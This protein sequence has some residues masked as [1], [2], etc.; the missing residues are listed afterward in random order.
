MGPL[1]L[2][3]PSPPGVDGWVRTPPSGPKIPLVNALLAPNLFISSSPPAY[4]LFPGLKGHWIG[5]FYRPN[6]RC[7]D[8]EVQYSFGKPMTK[9]VHQLMEFNG[10]RYTEYYSTCQGVLVCPHAGENS[11]LICWQWGNDPCATQTTLF[12]DSVLEIHVEHS[13]A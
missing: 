11:M 7:G 6:F 4:P 10:L 9:K 13:V 3:A 8:N 5:W 2:P 1:S 12:S